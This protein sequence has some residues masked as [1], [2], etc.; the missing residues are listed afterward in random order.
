VE[1]GSD[2]SGLGLDFEEPFVALT[3]ICSFVVDIVDLLPAKKKR[4]GGYYLVPPP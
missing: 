2:L 3:V 1:L 4:G